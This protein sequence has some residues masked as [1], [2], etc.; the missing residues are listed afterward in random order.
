MENIVIDAESNCGL[1]CMQVNR[2]KR[3]DHLTIKHKVSFRRAKYLISLHHGGKGKRTPCHFCGK[4][5]LNLKAHITR[6]KFRPR[7]VSDD[8]GLK[9]SRTAEKVRKSRQLPPEIVQFNRVVNSLKK[10]IWKPRYTHLQLLMKRT[11]SSLTGFMR[12]PKNTDKL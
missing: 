7:Y 6:C 8:E 9:I 3:F 11:V 1:C 2:G 12:Q 5:Q 4:A 10:G